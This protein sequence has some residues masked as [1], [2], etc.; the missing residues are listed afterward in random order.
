MVVVCLT[1]GQIFIHVCCLP[2]TA[3]SASMADRIYEMSDRIYDLREKTTTGA[4][5]HLFSM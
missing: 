1:L 4:H 3:V 2:N 5:P